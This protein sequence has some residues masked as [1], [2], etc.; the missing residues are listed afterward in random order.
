MERAEVVE[1][2]S[3]RWQRRA[4]ATVLCPHIGGDCNLVANPYSPPMAKIE[5]N[6]DFCKAIYMAERKYLT[7]PNKHHGRFCSPVCSQHAR[8]GKVHK[9]P[10]FACSLCETPFYRAP[11]KQRLSKSGMLF[12]SRACKDVAQ[13][14][15]SGFPEIHPAHFDTGASAYRRRALRHH[16]ARCVECGYDR[17]EV[18]LHVHHLD[19]DTTN[20][21]LS[22]LV[23]LCR[24]CHAEVHLA[25]R[26]LMV[27]TI[28][29]D[30]M[31]TGLQDQSPEPLV[32]PRYATAD[33]PLQRTQPR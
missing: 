17:F 12:C 33:S 5:R 24:N 9:E 7:R 26:K 28:G 10:N 14:V 13:S 31:R 4:L 2:S 27:E 32:S 25:G 11:S 22:N 16:G 6:C 19:R 3:Q 23:V 21:K 8:R 29:V 1:T 20:G 15:D 18:A 30:P